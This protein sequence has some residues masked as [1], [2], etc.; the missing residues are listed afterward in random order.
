MKPR[1]A[2]VLIGHGS[3]APGFDRAM[4]RVGR[5]ASKLLGLPLYRAYLGSADP[6]IDK[7]VAALVAKGFETL[8]LVPYFVLVGYHVSRDIRDCV[9]RLKS[10]YRRRAVFVL[11][12][13]LG[14]DPLLVRLVA[15][16]A[17]NA[18]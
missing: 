5:E 18:R 7:A 8:I 9:R 11:R 6:G 15:K 13:Y 10:R 2:V 1:T 4:K 3:K 16:R 12:D 17:R 14:Y